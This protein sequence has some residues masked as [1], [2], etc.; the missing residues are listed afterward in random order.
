MEK[1]IGSA[2]VGQSGGPTTAINAS[3]VGVI[4][5][6]LSEINA[7][8]YITKLYGMKNGIEG[9]LKEEFYVLS[10]I[11]S[12]EEVVDFMDKVHRFLGLPLDS[13]I[14]IVAEPKI[15]GLG[16]SAVYQKGIFWHGATRGDGTVG[17]DIT[18]NIKTIS[19]ILC[20]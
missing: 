19:D 2:V 1:L 14:D 9:F 20:L 4:R 12:E 10:D 8:G 17:E 18:E 13:P 3:L 5:G 11:F 7:S 15:D 6:C 16:Y